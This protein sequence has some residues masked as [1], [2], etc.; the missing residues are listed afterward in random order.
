MLQLLVVHLSLLFA[1][2]IM[3]SSTHA[4]TP[5]RNSRPSITWKSK[6]MEPL[7]IDHAAWARAKEQLFLITECSDRRLEA[8]R[9]TGDA[10]GAGDRAGV[11]ILHGM[12]NTASTVAP[13]QEVPN[14]ISRKNVAEKKRPRPSKPK[15]AAVAM[16]VMRPT[17]RPTPSKP[18]KA[19]A[20]MKVMKA[21]K[22][23]PR[24]ATKAM[25]AMKA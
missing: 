21:M 1:I 14:V 2:T 3:G 13:V 16:K 23:P 25:K 11:Q 19:A 15:K 5:S 4:V 6:D 8:C 9:P 12:C 7:T 10:N 17:K 22:A 24:K 20:A 18:E